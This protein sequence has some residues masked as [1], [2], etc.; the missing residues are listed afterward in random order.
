[1]IFW[2]RTII[3]SCIYF[4]WNNATFSQ[5]RD[6]DF[7][8]KTA[9]QN[10]PLLK[11]YQNQIRSNHIDSLILRAGMKPQIAGTAGAYY[12]P[13]IN[14][15]GYDPAITNYGSYS[16][17]LG[18]RKD[19]FRGGEFNN[20]YFSLHYISDSILYAAGVSERDLKKT[21]IAQYI[22]AYGDLEQMHYH[23]ELLQ[24]L[25]D[26]DQVLKKITEQGIYRQ[27]DYLTFHVLYQQQ[28]LQLKQLEI[29]YKL[30]YEILNYICGLVDTSSI[31]L[32][33]PSLVNSL[34]P[35]LNQLLF[36][37]PFI[38]DSLA[39]HNRDLLIDLNYR[40]RLSIFGDAGYETSFTFHSEKNFG[41]SFGANFTIPLY[42]GKQRRLLHE[43]IQ[44]LE[45]TRTR[46]R[47]FFVS[48]YQQQIRLL[49]E[50][51]KNTEDLIRD[52]H[53]QLKFS[54]GLIEANKKLIATGDVRISD[55]LLA[56]NN[57]MVAKNALLQFNISRYQVINQL[58]YWNSPVQ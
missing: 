40:P 55:F 21:V 23:S 11:D 34:L 57:Y 47:D 26:E 19:L 56:I 1:M 35:T 44:L 12:P 13:L 16:A 52:Y 29:Q 42:D 39:L 22:I 38:R 10:S 50:Q 53:D 7:Y 46:Y 18:I 24:F 33:D 28:Q 17:L 8:V 43:K 3:F 30:D 4:F 49:T 15:Y 36:S 27:T 58:N 2:K 37:K 25:G 5:S 45:D 51:L 48:Q 54:E 32:S 20:R 14:G 9:I 41:V 31:I 6:L